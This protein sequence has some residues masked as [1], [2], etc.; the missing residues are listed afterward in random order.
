MSEAKGSTAVVCELIN[1]LVLVSTLDNLARNFSVDLRLLVAELEQCLVDEERLSTYLHLLS[2][3]SKDVKCGEASL[4]QA[5]VGQVLQGGLSVLGD[6]ELIA[7]ALNS[8]ALICLYDDIGHSSLLGTRWIRLMGEAQYAALGDKADDFG[9]KM[10]LI[11]EQHC[12]SLKE[13]PQKGV[14]CDHSRDQ[15][16]LKMQAHTCL[17]GASVEELVVGAVALSGSSARPSVTPPVDSPVERNGGVLGGVPAPIQPSGRPAAPTGTRQGLEPLV[18]NGYAAPRWIWLDDLSAWLLTVPE[19]TWKLA[20]EMSDDA[21]DV[22]VDIETP[23]TVRK[24]CS[25]ADVIKI[26]RST[27]VLTIQVLGP[28]APESESNLKVW[29]AE[30]AEQA[31]ILANDQRIGF[32]ETGEGEPRLLLAV[33]RKEQLSWLEPL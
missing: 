2:S 23:P 8:D 33:G 31:E 12:R 4:T 22:E 9:S 3:V 32:L 13:S 14:A 5:L 26:H 15:R 10:Q 11:W 18:A 6:S 19:A 16:P 20:P 1:H 30:R 29:I 7:L 28:D 17:D 25:W 24:S 27:A 21:T